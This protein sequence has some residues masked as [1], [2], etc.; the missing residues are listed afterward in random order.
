MRSIVNLLRA[1]LLMPIDPSIN[2]KPFV[3][4]PEIPSHEI[5][6]PTYAEGE[7]GSAFHSSLRGLGRLVDLFGPAA[8]SPSSSARSI[9]WGLESI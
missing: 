2:A 7:S 3:P 4:G 6:M 8:S 9:T 1:L 5:S